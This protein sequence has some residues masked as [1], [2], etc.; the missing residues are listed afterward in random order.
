MNAG[1]CQKTITVCLNDNLLYNRDKRRNEF[2]VTVVTPNM[3][4]MRIFPAPS[5]D[6]TW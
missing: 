1:E 4:K 3:V 6:I 2:L 5:R